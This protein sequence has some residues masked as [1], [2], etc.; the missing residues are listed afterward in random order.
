M[1]KKSHIIYLLQEK[2]PKEGRM[3]GGGP[4]LGGRDRCQTADLVGQMALSTRTNLILAQALLEGQRGKKGGETS[5]DG[6]TG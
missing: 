6:G 2:T 1:V 3:R 4:G 5:G